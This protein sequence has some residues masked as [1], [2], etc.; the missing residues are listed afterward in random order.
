MANSWYVRRDVVD[1]PIRITD[2]WIDAHAA[3]HQAL[4]DGCAN[5]RLLHMVCGLRDEAELSPTALVAATLPRAEPGPSERTP[6]TRGPRAAAGRQGGHAQNG[7]PSA[8][9]WGRSGGPFR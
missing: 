1:D 3:F 2:G 8:N 5:R 9:K 4:L 6:R 7:G